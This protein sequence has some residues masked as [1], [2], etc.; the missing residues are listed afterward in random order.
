MAEAVT[1]KVEGLRETQKALKNLEGG[2]DDLK[3]T[4]ASLGNEIAQRAS[5]LAPRLTGNLAASIKSNRQAKK[6]SIKA[7]GA[8]VPYAGVIEYGWKARNIESRSYLRKAAF[9][10]RDYIVQK[11]EDG[12]K[13]VIQKYNFDR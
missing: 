5:A 8:K 2:L 11:Y 4:N 9:E 3:D 1:I 7:G 12:I 13:Q 6:V 10:N